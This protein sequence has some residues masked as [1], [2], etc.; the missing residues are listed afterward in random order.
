[1]KSLRI[2]AILLVLCMFSAV[3]LACNS[4]GDTTSGTTGT[5]GT[6]GT[7][8]TTGNNNSGN[9]AG[10]S[11]N[12]NSGNNNGGN[13]TPQK[14][15]VPNINESKLVDYVDVVDTFNG[16]AFDIDN[17]DLGQGSYMNIMKNATLEE[18]NTFKKQLE[19]GG[20]VLYTTNQIGNNLFATYISRSQ[21]MNVMFLVYDYDDTDTAS[22]PAAT[23][24]DHNEIRIMV[25]ERPTYSLPLLAEDNKYTANNTVEPK[26][27]MLS[28]NAISWP[29]RMG[30]LYQLADGSFFIIDG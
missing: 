16:K 19:D 11:G 7:T 17:I 24:I 10:N 28:D 6:S 25:D 9:N 29:G 2:I 30:Y 22:Y 12:N 27:L 3:L 13:T 15:N 23:S 1:M 8:G 5:M 14:P 21:I 18:Y 26:L 20:A 4:E